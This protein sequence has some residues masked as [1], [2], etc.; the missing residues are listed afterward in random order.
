MAS[1]GKGQGGMDKSTA[2]GTPRADL[3]GT[4]AKEETKKTASPGKVYPKSVDA[5]P[6][7]DT[8]P[9]F[10]WGKLNTKAL[11]PGQIQSSRDD[12]GEETGKS[13]EASNDGLNA[14]RTRKST[15]VLPGTAHGD[16]DGDKLSD[17][18]P[19]DST[20]VS[21]DSLSRRSVD[22]R[23]PTP[24]VLPVNNNEEEKT[25]SV[26]YT[27]DALI[28]LAIPYLPVGLAVTCLI[29]NILL[30]GS[31]TIISGFSIFCCGKARVP[32]KDDH[33]IVTFCVNVW[34]GV[35]QLFTIPLFLVGWF[36]SVAWGIRM[37]LLALQHRRE[38]K[39][40]RDKDLQQLAL[41]AFSSPRRPRMPPI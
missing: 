24:T 38:L 29:T 27:D 17:G 30:P 22:Y 7:K 10:A 41:S 2:S 3:N 36:W 32:T 26:V 40:Q 20:F 21:M 12:G 23:V 11:L 5:K 35:A 8:K 19:R 4:A 25:K 34:V 37:V 13:P 14:S 39:R 1:E 9:A 16:S 28:R 33:V 31:G 6:N 18:P 15:L